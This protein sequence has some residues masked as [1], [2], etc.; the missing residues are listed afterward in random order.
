MNTGAAP[1]LADL[2]ADPTI[3]GHAAFWQLNPDTGKLA[4]GFQVSPHDTHDWDA[5]EVPVLVDA[6]FNG[7]PRKLLLQASRNGYFLSSTGRM[8][9]TC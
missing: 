2:C 6:D 8:A 9:R 4:W 3:P 1:A 5:S 7:Q